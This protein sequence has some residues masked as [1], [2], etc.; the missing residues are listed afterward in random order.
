MARN[1]RG[2]LVPPARLP[3]VEQQLLKRRPIAPSTHFAPLP[4]PRGPAPYR[5][6]LS[7]ILGAEAMAAIA[8]AGVL[9]FHA[10]GDTGGWQDGLPQSEVARA[11]ADDLTGPDP[12]R[13]FYHLGDVVYPHGEEA[14][15]GPQFFS[16]Y[17][18]YRA[19]IFAI[20]GN[21]DA[22]APAA[23]GASSLDPFLRAFCSPAAPLHDAALAVRRPPADQP[24]V[25]WTLV[26]DWVWI[27]GMYGNVHEDGEVA[28]DQ[29]EWVTGELAAAPQDVTL[30]LAVHRPVY[31]IDIVHGSNLDL[32]DALDE[33][34][35]AAGRA[36]DAVFT[37]HSHNYQR[38]SRRIGRRR[39][40][41]VVAGAGG[42]HQRHALAELPRTPA[43]FPALPG[44]TL[45]AY[46][47][48]E[49]GYLTVAV[50]PSGADVAY[51]T[52][53]DSGARTFDVFALKP[54]SSR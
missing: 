37:A 11:M 44:V 14:N 17:A 29:L 28:S 46:Q 47:S 45:E 3:T 42:F 54:P 8:R 52:V 13:F 7:D 32:G 10:V 40:P 36:P 30:I 22:E 21:H 19:P 4:A 24:H 2:A 12:V 25:H 27:V 50:T 9:R 43:T 1:L 6:A 53:S 18:E 23:A 38:F 20:P 35:V 49:H 26:H 51:R 33:C 15:Y 5:R 48:T 16:P 41:Y 34:F 31:S 39:I